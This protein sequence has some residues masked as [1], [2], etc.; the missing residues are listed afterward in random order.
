MAMG[1]RIGKYFNRTFDFMNLGT[2]TY[3]LKYV[4]L[5][6]FVCFCFLFHL[7]HTLS[8]ISLGHLSKG[9]LEGQRKCHQLSVS[10]EHSPSKECALLVIYGYMKFCFLLGIPQVLK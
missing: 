10:L 5:Y 7:I 6:G 4:D 3:F 9:Y 1:M 2:L 8:Y